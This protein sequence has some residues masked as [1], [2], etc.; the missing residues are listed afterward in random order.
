MVGPLGVLLFLTQLMAR[1]SSDVISW[2]VAAVPPENISSIYKGEAA[3]KGLH[4]LLDEVRRSLETSERAT[5][6]IKDMYRDAVTAELKQASANLAHSS[7]VE[8]T[9]SPRSCSKI[10]T[11]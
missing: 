4:T 1:W 8:P 3:T 6:E 9:V 11:V 2:Y 10:R 5:R 7:T